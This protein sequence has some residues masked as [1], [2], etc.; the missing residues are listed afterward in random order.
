[1][2]LRGAGIAFWEAAEA[3]KKNAKLTKQVKEVSK[4]KNELLSYLESFLYTADSPPA[5]PQDKTKT[6]ETPQESGPPAPE[7][8]QEHKR[9]TEASTPPAPPPPP[10]PADAPAH[11]A[12]DSLHSPSTTESTPPPLSRAP[13]PPPPPPVKR[14]PAVAAPASTSGSPPPPPH[15]PPVKRPAAVAAPA[16]T[17]GSPPPP[18]PPNPRPPPAL[19]AAA[20]SLSTAETTQPGSLLDEIIA[21]K[22]KPTT[23]P[24]GGTCKRL[25]KLEICVREAKSEDTDSGRGPDVQNKMMKLIQDRLASSKVTPADAASKAEST[26]PETLQEGQQRAITAILNRRQGNDDDDWDDDELFYTPRGKFGQARRRF[27]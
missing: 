9:A 1:M 2:S 15:P 16:S 27:L 23:K 13:P 17:S 22:G 18:P 21:A 8:S 20:S 12:T 24:S 6:A 3:A 19:A 11:A 25:G 4:E 26:K 5:T 7:S 14:T 10:V